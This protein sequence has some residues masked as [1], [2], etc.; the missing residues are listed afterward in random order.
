MDGQVAELGMRIDPVIAEVRVDGVRAPTTPD[1]V[2][3]ALNKPVDVITTARDTHGRATVLGLVPEEPRVFPVGRLDKD[4][5][6]LL[7]L[8]NDGIFANQ[9]AHP[10]YGV[11]KTYVAEVKGSVEPA[12]LRRLIRGVPLSD[13]VAKAES[14]RLTASSRGRAV[15]ELVVR[16]GRNRLVRR[17]LD[18]VGLEV[19]RLAR[20][21]IGAVKLG[22]LKEG[23]WRHLKPDELRALL[24]TEGTDGPRPGRGSGDA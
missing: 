9:I 3:I 5:S 16:E 11:P 10:R 2:Y 6:G 23:T 15:V 21:S 19:T 4:T 20:T 1:A 7:L 13:G 14:A 24:S 22:R 18:A 17:L 12:K 8:T